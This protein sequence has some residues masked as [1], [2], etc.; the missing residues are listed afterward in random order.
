MFYKNELIS[1]FTDKQRV[2]KSP[3]DVSDCAVVA[4]VVVFIS[5]G[6]FEVIVGDNFMVV[7]GI[8]VVVA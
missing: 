6:V 5:V 2:K 3:G 1:A 8:L 7:I 4:V